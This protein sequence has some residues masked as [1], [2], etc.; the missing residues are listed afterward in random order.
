M[1]KKKLNSLEDLGGFVYSTNDNFDPGA[2]QEELETPSPEQQ[3]LTV[4]LEKK[5]RGGK[6]VV[7]V[8]GFEG[9]EDDLQELGKNLKKYCSCGGSVKEGEILIQGNLRDKVCAYLDK[10]QYKFKKVGA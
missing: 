1:A 8:K 6:T 7:I 5:G 9:K 2:D 4:H 3:E 10:H